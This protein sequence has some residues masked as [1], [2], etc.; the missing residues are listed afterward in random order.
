MAA[1]APEIEQRVREF[2]AGQIAQSGG[3][4]KTRR[5]LYRI[6]RQKVSSTEIGLSKFNQIVRDLEQAGPSEPFPHSKWKPW[7][8]PDESP[9]DSAFLL[10]IAV[11]KQAD[12]GTPLYS[13]EAKWGQRLRVA[14]E[15]LHP[16]GQYRLVLQYA[17]R[18]VVAYWLRDE[19]RTLDL[20]HF[21]AYKPW[22]P[23]THHAYE[24]A[25]ASGLAPKL[26]LDVFNYL[27]DLPLPEPENLREAVRLSWAPQAFWW[28]TPWGTSIP[29]WENDP[30]RADMIDLLLKFWSGNKLKLRRLYQRR[31]LVLARRVR[32]RN[33]SWRKE[34]FANTNIPISTPAVDTEED[35]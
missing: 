1:L 14:L 17:F 6:Y 31:P 7:T 22:L 4:P 24:L 35:L 23:R 5:E 28:L 21:I 2:W 13:H 3:K 11:I 10:R 9:E 30:V 16:F 29:G 20:D 25:L 12:S 15:G 34:H 18:E 19:L 27:S 8:H 26:K 33:Q 32:N